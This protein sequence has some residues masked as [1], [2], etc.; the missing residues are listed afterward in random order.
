MFQD[1]LLFKCFSDL[2]N[3]KLFNWVNIFWIYD[4]FV[5]ERLPNYLMS[6]PSVQASTISL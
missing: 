1:Y 6:N 3:P 4:L 5:L 2:I